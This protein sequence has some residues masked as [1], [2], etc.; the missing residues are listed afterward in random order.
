MHIAAALVIFLMASVAAHAQ[1]VGSIRDALTKMP[2]FLLNTPSAQFSF[3]DVAALR[4]LGGGERIHRTLA[5]RAIVGDALPHFVAL[6]ARSVEYWA[7]RSLVDLAS[8]RYLAGSSV[9]PVI[10]GF[11]S[12]DTATSTIAALDAA[13]FDAIEIEGMLSNRGDVDSDPVEVESFDPWRSAGRHRSFIAA[14]EDAIVQSIARGLVE[15]MLRD[16][17]NM[18]ESEVVSAALD[19]IEAALGDGMLVQALL[20]NPLMGLGGVDTEML[21]NGRPTLEEMREKLEA[22][23]QPGTEGIPSYLG[24]FIA[25]AQGD[26]PGVLISLTYP[27]CA[28]ADR[29]AAQMAERLAD[30]MPEDLRGDV[31]EAA[32]EASG[33]LCA[34]TLN[35]TGTSAD[36]LSNSTFDAFIRH[37]HYVGVLQIGKA[38]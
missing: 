8:I 26:Q 21:L 5:A 13:D 1:G 38:E 9:Q 17:P 6:R 2:K 23:L 3:V 34:A 31:A 16:E 36:G 11:D 30:I 32:I 7:E 35:V 33:G 15:A 19:G 37:R 27:D 25:D 12:E 22:E 29:A 18:A 24:G 10:W 28:T 14:K 4:K 20:V